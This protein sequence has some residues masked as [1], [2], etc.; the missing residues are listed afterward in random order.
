MLNDVVDQLRLQ[1]LPQYV[2]S[3]AMG[4][5]SLLDGRTSLAKRHFLD[6]LIYRLASIHLDNRESRIAYYIS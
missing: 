1:K 6:D 5:D 4:Y 3:Y 2:H